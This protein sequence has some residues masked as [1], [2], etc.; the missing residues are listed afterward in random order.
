MTRDQWI[1]IKS[2][3]ADTFTRLFNAPQNVVADN[4]RHALVV[5]VS[6]LHAFLLL[7][8]FEFAQLATKLEAAVDAIPDR[9]SLPH[10]RATCM[11]AAHHAMGPSACPECSP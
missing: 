7:H 4:D 3:D 6:Q 8:S 5:Y 9:E 2:R 11:H 1:A 10:P